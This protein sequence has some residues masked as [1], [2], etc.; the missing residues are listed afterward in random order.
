MATRVVVVGG[1]ALGPKAAC[2]FKRL[3]PDGVVTL[4]DESDRFSYGG[5][6]IPFYISGEINRLEDLRSTPYGMI[7][8]ENFFREAKG[9][10][11]LARRR[12][13]AIDRAAKTVLAEGPE[14]GR[15]ETIPY[16]KLVL[17]TGS[18]PKLPPIAG[19]DLAGITP[20]A[21][22]DEAEHIKSALSSGS[23]TSVAVVGGG[24][25]GLELAVAVADLWGI[26]VSVVETAEHVLPATLSPL[27]GR[28]AAADLE[29]GGVSV[30]CGEKVLRFEGEN[31][32]VARVVTDMRTID[33]NLVIMAA[34][35]TPRTELAAKAGLALTETGLILVDGHLRTS[36]PDIYSGGD[37]AAVQHQVTGKPGWFPLGSQAN[38]QGRIIGTNLAGGEAVFPGAVGAWCIKLFGQSAAGAGL[39]LTQARAAGF[40]AAAVH[41][42]HMDRAHFYPEHALMALELVVDIPSRRVLGVQG[43]GA[44]G[45][46]LV[47]R[48]NA[49]A[50]VIACQGSVADVCTL[51]V[52]YSPPF[53][54]AM[55]IVN[56]LGNVAENTLDGRSRTMDVE[57]FVRLWTERDGDCHYFLDTRDPAG[58]EKYRAVYPEHWHSIPQ[59]QLRSRIRE[60]PADMPVVLICNTGL[61]AFEAQSVLDALG[62]RDTL[63]V[64]GGLAAV[65]RAGYDLLQRG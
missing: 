38:R 37:C 16:D 54:S 17:A 25:T 30:F 14:A 11:V 13:T 64:A 24:F 59:D 45:D 40:E 22:L 29:A 1:V 56:V 27:L 6:G 34:G 3:M 61:R 8:D 41:V 10:T 50:Q 43:L 57:T 23:V 35:V 62:R 7:R 39:T 36:D 20:V 63:A 5:C 47:G 48:I 28:M 51:E 46:A 18:R 32:A 31:G 65:G 26:P 2:R 42:E 53:A 60:I 12:V 9:V 15:L 33:A 44:A 21:T 52:A 49:L 19:I 55:D 58:A 4:I